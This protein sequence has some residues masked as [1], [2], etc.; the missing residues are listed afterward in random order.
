MTEIKD[1]RLR[2]MLMKEAAHF[3]TRE[4]NRTSL[5]TITSIVLSDR[6]KRATLFCTVFP[7][8]KEEE[9]MKFLKRQRSDF[10]EHLQKQTRIPRIPFIDFAID[11]GEKNRQNIERLSSESRQ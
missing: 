7:E 2:E 10:R 8:N 9:A 6:A 1:D 11:K 4:S 3:L 5:I